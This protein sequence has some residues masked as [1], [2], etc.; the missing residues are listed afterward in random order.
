MLRD[1]ELTYQ[2]PE[3][4]YG[5]ADESKRDAHFQEGQGVHCNA[6]ATSPIPLTPVF[7]GLQS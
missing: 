3:R 5:E 1:G 2:K 6:E 4:R 7:T